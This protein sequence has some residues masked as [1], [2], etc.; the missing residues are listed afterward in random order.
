M[1]TTQKAEISQLRGRMCRCGERPE[2]VPRS[3]VV[4]EGME[5]EGLDYRTDASFRTPEPIVGDGVLYVSSPHLG[6]MLPPDDIINPAPSMPGGFDVP[7]SVEGPARSVVTE[8]IEIF[9]TEDE[10][11]NVVPT[12][13][14]WGW[15]RA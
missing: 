2:L 8:L 15:S 13:E 9:D 1:I 3:P 6:P 11:E 7:T 12:H 10:K 5:E 4:V 14:V